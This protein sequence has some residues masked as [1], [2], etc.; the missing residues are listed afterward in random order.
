MILRSQQVPSLAA[1]V[2]R[3]QD[4]RHVNLE[5]SK[6]NGSERPGTSRGQIMPSSLHNRYSAKFLLSVAASPACVLEASRE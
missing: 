2:P 1:V 3:G 6:G 5:R 4:Q